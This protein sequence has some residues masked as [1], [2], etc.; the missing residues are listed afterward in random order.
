MPNQDLQ[1]PVNYRIPVKFLYSLIFS[2]STAYFPLLLRRYTIIVQQKFIKNL[3]FLLILNIVVKPLWILGIQITVQNRVGVD[4]FG[5]YFT[6]LN[7]GYLFFIIT[8]PGL[9]NYT[10]RET[11]GSPSFLKSRF[12]TIGILKLFLALFYGVFMIAAGKYIMGYSSR[13]L[14]LLTPVILNIMLSSFLLFLR[15]ALGGLQLFVWDSI[16]GVL[17]RVLM[18]GLCSLFLFAPALNESFS[19]DVFIYLQTAA[20]ITTTIYGVSILALKKIP[21]VFKFNIALLGEILKN[22]YPYALL[23]LL[24][25]FYT[26]IDSVMIEK[27]YPAGAAEAGIYAQGFKLYEAGNMIAVLFAGLLLPVFSKM[28]ANKERV[29]QIVD[30]SVRLLVIPAFFAA[31]YGTFFSREI[32]DLLFVNEVEKTTAVFPILMWSFVA[33]AI[34]YVYGTLLTAGGKLRFLNVLSA[35]GLATNLILNYILIPRY[36]ALGAACATLITQGG[37]AAAQTLKS[38]TGYALQFRLS[39]VWPVLALA[40]I[41]T[42]VFFLVRT[43]DAPTV[44]V[45]TVMITATAVAILYLKLI[46]VKA[47]LNLLKER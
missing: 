45:L 10:N 41:N 38:F 47:F 26:R 11:S 2:S 44:P 28:L 23:A 12:V 24:M 42:A 5:M 3:A 22:S 9:N 4:D 20:Y 31:L 25:S 39:V 37:V 21:L 46:D 19:I 36:G 29:G 27:M 6:L 1:H 15:A 13:F 34:N 17:D 33:V 30:W 35:I 43:L 32:I 8:D 40:G 7:F 16:A 14:E 18:I